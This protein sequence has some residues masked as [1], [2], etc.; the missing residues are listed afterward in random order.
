MDE[1]Q[2]CLVENVFPVRIEYEFILYCPYKNEYKNT[3][4][5]S[6]TSAVARARKEWREGISQFKVLDVIFCRLQTNPVFVM[7]TC[8][9]DGH[10]QRRKVRID[11][12]KIGTW[13]QYTAPMIR[14]LN[15]GENEKK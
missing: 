12:G 2:T 11:K 14:D 15:G 1:N 5:N 9:L 13:A 4:A 3:W 10:I 7:L 6:L 8:E